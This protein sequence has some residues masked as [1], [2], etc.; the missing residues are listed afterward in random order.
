MIKRYDHGVAHGDSQIPESF[1]CVS[2]K[3]AYVAYEDYAALQQKLDAMADKLARSEGYSV[4]VD[5][6][7]MEYIKK[8]NA[9]AA[10][11]AAL[12]SFATKYS[13]AVIHWNIWADKED[14]LRECPETPATDA[15]LN[16][17][18]AEGVEMVAEAIGNSA[19]KLKAGSKDW[20][21]LKSIVFTLVNFAAQLRSDTHDTADKA[22]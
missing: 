8:C 11:S 22:G 1:M 13:K 17:V 19:S 10:E 20:K 21:S 5:A 3:G 14:K 9:M 12:K 4:G 18:R 15:Y 7:R 16:S 2:D 6:E